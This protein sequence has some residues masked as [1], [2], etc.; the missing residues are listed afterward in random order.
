MLDKTLKM[1]SAGRARLQGQGNT[2]KLVAPEPAAVPVVTL[3]T[4]EIEPP[5]VFDQDLG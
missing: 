1:V 3:I 4:P 2:L 5:P